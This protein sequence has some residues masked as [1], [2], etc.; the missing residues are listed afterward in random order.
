MPPAMPQTVEARPEVEAAA[1]VLAAID[2]TRLPLHVAVIMDGNGR[3]AEARGLDR[4]EGHAAGVASVRDTV[5]AAAG[6]GLSTLTLFAFSI[7]NWRRPVEE[8]EA[9]ME[10]VKTYLR[11]ETRNLISN[12]IR[13]RAL[14]R[15]GELPGDVRRLVEETETATAH[16]DG[17]SLNVA[18]NYG[19]RAE[20]VDAAR[21]IAARALEEGRIPEVDEAAFAEHLSTRGMPDPDLLIRTSGEMRVSNFLLFQSAYT[22]FWTT[23]T[24]W[25]D[26]RRRDLYEAV[27]VYQRRMRRFGGLG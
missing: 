12:S 4:I 20:I 23:E 1:A 2:R 10:L 15:I 16:C 7:E 9:L 25:P 17:L 11:L 19:G 24:L 14:G 6:L 26:F 5:E 13:F 18:L 3:W 8:V 21:E 22:E 27:T